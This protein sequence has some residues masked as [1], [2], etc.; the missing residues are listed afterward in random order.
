MERSAL[1]L[2]HKL[3]LGMTLFSVL[4]LVVAFVIVNVF[5]RNE[6]YNNIIASAQN[7]MIIYA[8]ELDGWF[9]NSLHVLDS[10]AVVLETVNEEQMRELSVP[11]VNAHDYI[12]MGFIGIG[13]ENR[14]ISGFLPEDWTPPAGFYVHLRPWYV[15]AMENRG[16]S[17]FTE[18]Y[19]SGAYP[20]AIVISAGRYLPNLAGN[21]VVGIDIVLNDVMEL[22]DSYNVPEGGYLFLLSPE[23]NIVSHPHENFAPTP[24]GMR[25]I[26]QFPEYAVLEQLAGASFG[27]ERFRNPYGVNSYIMTF[28]IE[29]TGWT[30]VSVFPVVVTERPV[31]RTLLII[32]ATIAIIVGMVTLFSLVFVSLKFIRP[33]SKISANLNEVA[34]GNFD[35]NLN[36]ANLS[37]DEIGLLTHD[38]GNLVDNVRGLVTDFETMTKEHMA[39]RYNFRLDE[40]RYAGAYA[41]LIEQLNTMTS[42][43]VQDT[44]EMIN[45][46]KHYSEG[47]FDCEVRT[48]EGDWVWANE[49]MAA[50]RTNF[51]N[52]IKD[53]DTLAK[54]AVQGNFDEKADETKF[55]GSWAEI[56]R[57]LNN[58]VEAVEKPIS[59]IE[60]E[61]IQMSKGEFSRLDGD[62]KGHF[63]AMVDA[64]NRTNETTLS[65][66]SEI[67]DVLSGIANGDL[68]VSVKSEFIGAY[69]PIKT[70]LILIT[71]ALNK[72]ISEIYAAS[73][74]VLE[75][76][77]RITSNAM[78]LAE[79]SNS[80]A[81]SLEELNTSVELVNISTRRFAEN[82]RNANTLSSTST[83]NAQEGNEAMKQMLEAM[84]QI[85]DSSS[86][87]SKIIKAIQDIAFQTNLLALNAAVE[88]ARAGEHGKGFAVVAEEVRNLAARSQDAASETTNLISDS[89]TR[90]ESGTSIAK[91]TS[92]SFDTIVS[93][94]N[95]VLGLI[96]NITTDATEQAEMISQISS[97]L[98]DTANTV[99]DNSKFAQEAAATAEELN[100]QSEMLQELVS[101]FK[102]RGQK[103]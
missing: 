48:Y 13:D 88:A 66:I 38:V 86:N 91:T 79:S 70:A 102:I 93:T 68:S 59:L 81:A 21:A 40:S 75:G 101:F 62:F 36:R 19:V 43:Y 5:V 45:V 58:L 77:K 82:A 42:L 32:L 56:I 16:R 76:A 30:L 44:V 11:F 7:N 57:S 15:A 49:A 103:I 89:I 22:L 65:Y 60:H 97:I 55:K 64:Y 27:R 4:G 28:P 50:M 39:G 25:N 61:L 23:G 8:T 51:I 72:I 37:G 52:V 78:E 90:V 12:I 74:N 35:I 2:S 69:A 1:R 73:Q 33:I 92:A 80:Q 54:N 14:A 20:Y 63:A 67:S 85:K 87:I 96:N 98:L 94:A 3:I 29:S 26:N 95:E 100:S 10:M 47:N 31:W 9:Q 99:Q 17:A 46:V 84:L 53:I 18:P 6:V 71:E 34:K 83:N 41:D 24:A